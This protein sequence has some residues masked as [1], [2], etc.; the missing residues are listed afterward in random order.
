MAVG[1]GGVSNDTG[2]VKTPDDIVAEQ[3][4]LGAEQEKKARNTSDYAD[5]S[6]LTEDEKKRQWDD[7]YAELEL[8]RAARSA[9]TCPE[10]VTEKSPKGKA[11]VTLVFRNDGH[12]KEA[13]VGDPYTDTAVGKCVLR[14]MGAVIVRPYEGDE[15]TL[16]W[17][18]D[19]TGGK[20][21]GRVGGGDAAASGSE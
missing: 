12:V 10:S 2:G 1:C 15:K 11:P 7:P 19:L 17:E 9:E 13:R 4:A 18:I 14:A 20:K 21:S 8:K 16:E 5:S 3:E 6:E